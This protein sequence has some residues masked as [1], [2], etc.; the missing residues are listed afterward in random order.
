LALVA[1]KGGDCPAGLGLPRLFGRL[2][3]GA[4]FVGVEVEVEIGD[5]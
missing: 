5:R 1:G 4:I 3:L 2:G